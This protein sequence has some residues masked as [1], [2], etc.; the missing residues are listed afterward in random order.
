MKTNSSQR[1]L[2]DER[3]REAG[4][5]IVELMIAVVI[6]GVVGG[7]VVSGLTSGL[8]T[9]VRAQERVEALTDL[10]TSLHRVAREIRGSC[11]VI[12]AA[13]DDITVA[14]YRQGQEFRTRFWVPAVGRELRS[15]RLTFNTATNAWEPQPHRVLA[16]GITNQESPVLASFTY[17]VRDETDGSRLIATSPVGLPVSL[18]HA[19]EVTLRLQLKDG[20]TIVRSTLVDLRNGGSPCPPV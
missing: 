14:T 19:V 7:M 13:P 2:V 12:A 3:P 9:S 11:P 18:L 10:E 8:R 15:A 17:L 6:M 20:D 4:V 1:S 16:T 5:G